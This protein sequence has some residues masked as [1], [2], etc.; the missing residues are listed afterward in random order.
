MQITR[1]TA[2]CTMLAAPFWFTRLSYAGERSPTEGKVEP[3]QENP[4][5]L[6]VAGYQYDRVAALADGRVKVDN[7]NLSFTKDTIGN[8]NTHI[9]SGPG[10][11]DVTEV[12]LHPYILAYANEGFRD[13]TLLPIFPLRV[14]RHKSIFIRTDRGITRPED[15]RGKKIATPGYSSTSLTWIRGILE[16]EYGVKPTDIEWY[17]S[18]ADSSAK[19][20]GGPS[21]FENILPKNL[22]VEQGPA[23]KDESDMLADGD[24]DALFHAME[25]KCYVEGHPKVSRL[26]QDFRMTEQSYYKKTGIFPIMHAVAIRKKLI[27]THPWISSALFKAYAQAKATAIRELTT[28]GW[29]YITLP[30][31]A[32]E[33]EE[34]R[35]L[36]G[37]NFWPYGI[38][39]NRKTL[40]TFCRYSHQQGL[41]SRT[42][43]IEELFHPSS[44]LLAEK[45]EA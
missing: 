28:L 26:F 42:L 25:P 34:T 39:P 19:D 9:F 18:A 5:K 17:V 40:E 45:E 35:S 15:L 22:R 43:K 29:A 37:K 24:V 20:T 1:R 23:G 33:I 31:L 41:A 14:F 12:G 27:D 36:M 2:L 44:M 6:R 11:R 38:K 13:Y 8:L 16:D 4:I 3:S 7:C 30:W 10:T 32:Q 21:K